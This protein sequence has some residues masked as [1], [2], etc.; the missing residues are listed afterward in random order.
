MFRVGATR[1]TPG[2]VTVRVGTPIATAG[3]SVREKEQLG[4]EAR[5]Q[6][7]AMLGID[8]TPSEEVSPTDVPLQVDAAEQDQ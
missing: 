6:I 2:R 3:R 4:Q 1:V 7:A 5:T 8:A